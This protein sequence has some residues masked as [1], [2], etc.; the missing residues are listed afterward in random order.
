MEKENEIKNHKKI[1]FG[2]PKAELHIH[3]TGSIEPEKVVHLSQKNKIGD[4]NNV[5]EIRKQ[6]NFTCLMNYLKLLND[7]QIVLKEEDDFADIMYEY[8]KKSAIQGLVYAEIMF[9][10]QFFLRK[11]VK[12]ETMIRGYW[13]GIE[14]GKKDFNILSELILLIDRGAPETEAL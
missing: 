8:L 10:P 11:G 5:E 6:F 12:L 13:K 3:V 14:K 7:C 2:I 9:L 4:F 1:S